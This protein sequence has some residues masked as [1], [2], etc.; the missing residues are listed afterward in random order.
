M[1]NSKNFVGHC[2]GAARGLTL[3]LL[4]ALAVGGAARDAAAQQAGT[5]ATP[6]APQ[7]TDG[8]TAATAPEAAPPAETRRS[9]VD[10]TYRIGPGDIID[11]VVFNRPQLSRAGAR[12]DNRGY[13]RMPLLEQDIKASCLT[14]SELAAS[15]AKAYLEY[16][17]N[18]RV[19]VFV[20]DYQSQPVAVI[21]AVNAAGRFQLQRPIRLLELLVYAGGPALSAGK[22][23]QV[24]HASMGNS[25]RCEEPKAEG[26]A[27]AAAGA[28][29]AEAGTGEDLSMT[30]VYD[31]E[32]TM[33]GED[34]SNPYIR[35]GDIVSLA[36]ADEAYILGNVNQPR[37]L[38]LNEDITV[39]R[40]IA[41]CGGLKPGSKKKVRIIRQLPGAP[42]KE[43][44]VDLAAI[45]KKNA[46]DPMLQAN[47]ILE[48]PTE[49]GF[50]GVLRT[51]KGMV[52]S[53][54]MRLPMTVIP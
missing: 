21:G 8:A 26:D 17:K 19:D 24:L 13:I 23:I 14:E 30:T 49:G 1:K 3:L 15:I 20:R 32:R 7:K 18:P 37:S 48:V 27:A 53:Y 10:S 28:T 12:V 31:R 4:A 43:I 34:K 6:A 22:T 16:Q 2:Y 54:A 25:A 29:E 39:S 11:V 9:A 42:K 51:M 38:T 45:E 46:E 40:A 44:Y 5:P 33:S 36:M 47:D 52:G 50:K 35:P 41:M